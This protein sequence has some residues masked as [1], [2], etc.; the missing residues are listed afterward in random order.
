MFCTH[1]TMY[2]FWLNCYQAI[3]YIIHGNRFINCIIG[4][5][6]LGSLLHLNIKWCFSFSNY[7]SVQIVVCKLFFKLLSYIEYRESLHF[8]ISQFV[9]PA[10]SWF[11]FG[12][13]FLILK[14]KIQKIFFSD[15][16]FFFGNFFWI[17][18]LDF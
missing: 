9:I 7:R 18:F 13:S 17:F 2:T 11:Y 4:P 3:S 10:I 6:D 14:K 1:S 12:P 16:F 5:N 8:V 15:F